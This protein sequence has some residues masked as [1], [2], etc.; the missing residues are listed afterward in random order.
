LSIHSPTPDSSRTIVLPYIVSRFMIAGGRHGGV[1][2]DTPCC[3]PLLLYTGPS[4][5]EWN[6][7][8]R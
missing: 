3:R 5:K 6:D 7:S 8:F 4:G 1:S 2:E